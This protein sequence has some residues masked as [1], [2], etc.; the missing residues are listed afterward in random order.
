MSD[1]IINLQNIVNAMPGLVAQ[2][3]DEA[4]YIV[5]NRA[6]EN[7]EGHNQSGTLRRSITHTVDASSRTCVVGTDV[8]YAEAFHEGHGS[9]QGHP[10]LEQA[11]NE[12]ITEVQNCFSGLLERR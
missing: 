11:F 2:A 8:E 10:F 12:T 3:L 7:M 9:W 5:E 1:M 6:K 4:G